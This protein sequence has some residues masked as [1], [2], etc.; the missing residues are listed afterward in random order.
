[1]SMITK[2]AIT[3]RAVFYQLI[4]YG[5]LLFLIVGNEVFDFPHNV[6]GFPATPINWQEALIECIYIIALSVF[7]IYLTARFLKQIRFLEGFLPVCS[8]CHKIRDDKSWKSLEAYIGDH[9]E[10]LLSHG[11]CPECAEKHYGELLHPG[12][13]K[14]AD[15][16]QGEKY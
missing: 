11:L 12:K 8:Y 9:S 15:E 1:M 2:S 14:P 4:G 10:A 3:T 5:V 16:G 7:S 13:T 6:F